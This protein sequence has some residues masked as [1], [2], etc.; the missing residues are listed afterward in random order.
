MRYTQAYPSIGFICFTVASERMG[1]D[2]RKIARSFDKST[3]TRQIRQWK[4][5][6]YETNASLQGAPEG[7]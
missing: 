4:A 6:A 1:A 5:K 3:T 7:Y 2:Q